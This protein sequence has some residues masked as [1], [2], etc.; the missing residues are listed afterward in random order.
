M[1]VV[2]IIV[3][4]VVVAENYRKNIGEIMKQI[5]KIKDKSRIILKKNQKK[6]EKFAGEA[7]KGGP[8]RFFSIFV[9]LFN[10]ID[11]SFIFLILF[12]IFPILLL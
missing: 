1:I 9:F 2:I 6:L 11:F 3:V 12:I 5:R 4:V 8:T 7:P 10:I